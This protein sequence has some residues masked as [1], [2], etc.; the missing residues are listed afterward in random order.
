MATTFPLDLS[1]LEPFPDLEAKVLHSLD[2]IVQT[3][4][5]WKCVLLSIPFPLSSSVPSCCL[6]RLPY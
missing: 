6:A 2:L 1:L 5:R 4:S 3:F